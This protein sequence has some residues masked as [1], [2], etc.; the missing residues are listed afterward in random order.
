VIGRNNREAVMPNEQK[1]PVTDESPETANI[2][3]L[4]DA[5]NLFSSID[6]EQTSPADEAAPAERAEATTQEAAG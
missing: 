4:I 6:S 2:D 1:Q 3:A 5:L